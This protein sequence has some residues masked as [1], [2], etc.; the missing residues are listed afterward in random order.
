M[1]GDDDE[2]QFLAI[3]RLALSMRVHDKES[4]TPRTGRCHEKPETRHTITTTW[5]MRF[6]FVPSVFSFVCPFF[7]SFEKFSKNRSRR[8]D[9]FGPK[10]VKIGAILAIFLSLIKTR[11]KKK[12]FVFF[13]GGV[14]EVVSPVLVS[15]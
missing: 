5:A 8:C 13:V 11:Y 6:S 4:R 1:S 10:I 2:V 9:D 12:F 14:L 15:L 3:I 7:R